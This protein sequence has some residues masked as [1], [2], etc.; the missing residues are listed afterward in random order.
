MFGDIEASLRKNLQDREY[1]EEYARA[2]LNSYIATQIKVIREQRKM[3]QAELGELI[4]T[5][6]AG[7]S[8]VEDINYSSWSLRTLYKIA[9]A[10]D[11]RLR[12]SFEP[13]GTLPDEVVRLDR[14]RLE[15]VERAKDTAIHGRVIEKMPDLGAPIDIGAFR[16]LRGIGQ[17][18][19]QNEGV[20]YGDASGIESAGTSDDRTGLSEQWRE[21][22]VRGLRWTDSTK[23]RVPEVSLQA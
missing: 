21:D 17:G 8:R 2:Y 4:G 11:V 7:V 10:F 9:K 20:V 18:S 16:A 5:T 22:Q 13:Y 15:R 6:Q 23:I 1:A 14:A 12:V 3:T 19:R